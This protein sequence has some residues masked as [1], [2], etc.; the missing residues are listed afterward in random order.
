M[1][2]NEDNMEQDVQTEE[3]EEV[4]KWTQHPPED[5]RGC[6]GNFNFN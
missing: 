1:Q 6:G 2:T 3:I 5:L 4:D